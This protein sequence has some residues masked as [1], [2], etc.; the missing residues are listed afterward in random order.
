MEPRLTALR[1]LFILAQH[2]GVQIPSE[3]LAST[4]ESDTIRLLLRLMRAVQLSGKVLKSRKWN[5]LSS[6]GSAYPVMAELTDG[7]W[8]IVVGSIPLADG[9][10]SLAVLDPRNEQEGTT[11]VSRDEFEGLWDG[12]LLLCKRVY[13]LTDVDQP[14]GFRWFGIVLMPH[15]RY[16]WDMAV[17][18]VTLS[19]IALA[20]PLLFQLMIDKVVPHHSYTTMWSL[21]SVFVVLALFEGLFGYSRS[22]LTMYLSNKADAQLAS[23]TYEHVLSLPLP[24]FESMPTGVLVRNMLQTESIRGFLTG[25]LFGTLLDLTTLPI[26]MLGLMYYS[27]K[28]TLVVLLFSLVIAIVVGAMIPMFRR[29]LDYLY[30][31]EGARQADLV[32]TIH[33]V[34]AVKSLA[35]ESARQKL[36]DSKVVNSIR[37]RIEVFYISTGGATAVQVLQKLMSIAILCLGVMEIFDGNLTVGGLVAFFMLSGN[38]SGPLVSVVSL[39]NEYQQVA[40]SVKMLGSVM[41][42]PPERN[43]NQHGIHPPITGEM[44]FD[45]V[46]FT[47]DGAPRPALN[48]ISFK[49]EAGQMIGIVGRSGSGKTTVTRLIQGISS[50]QEGLIRLNGIDLRHIDL[51]Y[52]RRNIGVVL[53]E[54]VLFRGTLRDNIAVTK[55][56]ASLEEVMEA[57]RLAGADEF[58]DRLPLSYETQVEEGAT[59]FSGGQRQRLAIARALLARP[60][61]LIFDEAT[62]ALDP[63]SEAI[64]Q[65]NLA[66]IAKGRTMIIV[67]HRLS[68]LVTAD[69]ILVLE[70]GEVVDFA[71]HSVLLERC[72]I[73][74]HLWHQQNRHIQ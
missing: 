61:L 34:R 35:L 26:L 64:I 6:L 58:I 18:S 9:S 46:Q 70:R 67:S 25:P 52:L 11:L 5:D 39:V 47:Y 15:S 62:S 17:L 14:F 63:D 30:S 66:D 54:N 53:Q 24:F 19:M 20:S 74:R 48:H 57:A 7:S 27:F 36:W 31:A 4:H 60:N 44:E 3:L 33:G 37:C 13:R 69:Q 43:P 49:V 41:N 50:P 10:F 12:R 59:N 51:P 8:V 65:Q 42:Y 55:P 73:Y 45:Q 72:D 71:S 2:H 38:V 32:E 56:D 21:V 68:S 28:L 22:V 40:L 23:R 1:C 16:L 29:K